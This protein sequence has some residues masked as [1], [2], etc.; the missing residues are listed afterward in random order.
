MNRV[1]QVVLMVIISA[2]P[3]IAIAETPDEQISFSSQRGEKLWNSQFTVSGQQ[4]S[5]ASCHTTD[6]RQAGKHIR[7]GKVIQ[8]M[9]PSVNADRITDQSKINKWF[10][11]NCKWTLG[12]VCTNQEKGDVLEYLKS[13]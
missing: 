5:C 2:A 13:L 8:A 6:P 10:K 3:A 4:R 7:T 12:R 9:A 1:I 11:R